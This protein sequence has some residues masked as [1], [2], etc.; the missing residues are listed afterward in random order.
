MVVTVAGR[1]VHVG[2]PG[3]SEIFEGRQQP[4]K[5]LLTFVNVSTDDSCESHRMP[6]FDNPELF[7][8][9][10]EALP[11]A[12]YLVDLNRRILFW[13]A[14]AEELTGYLRQD[15]VGRFLREHLI[16]SN[17]EVDLGSNAFDP[18]SLAFKDG[19]SSIGDVSI[20][21][22]QGYRVPVVLRTVP[23]R[24]ERG[25][26]VGVAEC[27]EKHICVSDQTRRRSAAVALGS[28]DLMTGIPARSFMES[29]L[30]KQLGLY[31][32]RP[33]HFGILL[34]QVDRLDQVRAGRGPSVIPAVLRVVV[35]S[36]E[37]SLRQTDVLGCWSG[38]QFL[39]VLMECGEKESDVESVAN[40]IRKM[41][42][43]SEIEWWGDKFSVTASFGGAQ[44][45]PED[46]LES[47]MQ[48]AETSL[49]E[50]IALGGNRVTV[51]G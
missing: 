13:N 22:K 41:I 19:K 33:M 35:Q 24:N 7:R 36:I 3:G 18:L 6:E 4:P 49:L 34:V 23:I 39:S 12:V 48:R 45:R 8:S 42:G 26:V 44:N 43:Q 14:G 11:T 31:T 5:I 47:L 25:V 28:I 46:I 50:S 2:L 9:I 15:V 16:E 17:D 32:K 38:Y 21:H 37:N 27:F 29:H 10:L 20:L 40:R 51:V 1:E 30:R